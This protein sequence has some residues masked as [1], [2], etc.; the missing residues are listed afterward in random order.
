MI[1]CFTELH[2]IKLRY[3]KETQ[4]FPVFVKTTAQNAL[5]MTVVEEGRAALCSRV[6]KQVLQLVFQTWLPAIYDSDPEI[7]FEVCMNALV[8]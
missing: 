2:T 5:D 7:T 6:T 8:C 1:R 4:V 3:A